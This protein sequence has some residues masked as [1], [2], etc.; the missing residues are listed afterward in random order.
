LL[1]FLQLIDVSLDKVKDFK[2]QSIQAP[3]IQ[4]VCC[5]NCGHPAE[6]YQTH[7]PA[8]RSSAQSSTY[9]PSIRTQCHHC[10]YLMVT[11]AQTGCVIEAYAPGIP[12][13]A[14]SVAVCR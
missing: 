11:C 14:S 5:P 7:Q 1:V 8:S 10:D 3:M 4:T 12:F 6:R 9:K 2:M 13:I